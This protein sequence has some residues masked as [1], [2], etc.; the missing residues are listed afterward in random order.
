LRLEVPPGY[1]FTWKP[2]GYEQSNDMVDIRVHETREARAAVIETRLVV[3]R[4]TRTADAALA[5]EAALSQAA[6]SLNAASLVM[7]P[8]PDFNPVALLQALT[9][10][11]PGEARLWTLLGRALLERS[12]AQEAVEAL[13][14]AW[15]LTPD[16]A[17][18]G[19]LLGTAQVTAGQFAAASD[20][21]AELARRPSAPRDVFV[22][23]A[24]LHLRAA[25]PDQALATL[26]DGVAR[27]PDD[28]ELGRRLILALAASGRDEEAL[29]E[30]HRQAERHPDD[31][32]A[33]AELADLASARG[34][35][36]AAE[37]AYRMA[38]M[39]SPEDARLI[40]NLAWAL[41]SAPSRRPEALDLARRAVKLDPRMPAAWDTLAELLFLTGD[42]HGALAAN[43]RA[44]ALSPADRAQYEAHRRRYEA[45]PPAPLS[46][47]G[48]SR[49]DGPAASPPAPAATP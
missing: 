20:T 17:E 49:D 34:D 42:A 11:R 13:R 21:L 25:R 37:R 46:E 27:R 16:D 35:T 15:Q 45:G 4:P 38:L 12:R 32:R 3:K 2:L 44:L 33:Q 14:T 31:A 48:L 36:E 47:D 6:Q 41:R 39:H 22:T 24:A 19:T 26:R 29:V 5:I 8:G 43:D 9:Q 23:L 28:V 18:V 40:N 10:E 7:A 1:R 30:A